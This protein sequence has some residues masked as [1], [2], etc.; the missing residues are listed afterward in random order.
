VRSYVTRPL[1]VLI[2]ALVGASAGSATRQAIQS[3]KQADADPSDIVIAAPLSIVLL[4]TIAGL[5]SRRRGWIVAFVG[6]AVAGTLLGEDADRY[7]K[8]AVGKAA[9]I[10]ARVE[11]DG[12]VSGSITT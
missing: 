7:M 2:A 12:G 6:G 11:P 8:G 9:S 10:R 3:R 5:L 4:A 1:G